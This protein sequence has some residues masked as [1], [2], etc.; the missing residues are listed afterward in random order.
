MFNRIRRHLPPRFPAM[1]FRD[2]V[3]VL[4]GGSRGLGLELARRFAAEG[5]KVALLARDP[6]ELNRA[7]TLLGYRDV[8]AIPCDVTV[9]EQVHTAVHEVVRTWGR[10]DV[11]VNN[12]GLI[13]VGPFEHM[14]DDDWTRS[15]DLHVLAPLHLVRACLP[16]MG[17][18]SRIV[19][20]SS[21]GGLVP[22]PHM[23]P[24][25]ASKHALVGLSGTLRAE[26]APR[27]IAVTTVC[28]WLT[29]TGSPPHV[30]VKGS[31]ADEYRWFAT[32]DN[33]PLLSQASDRAARRIVAATRR[34]DARL[35]PTVHGKL[36]VLAE[37]VAPGLVAWLTD[38][39][40]T[41]LPGPEPADGDTTRLGRD[42]PGPRWF[43]P[44]LAEAGRR[45]NE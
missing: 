19:N 35:V 25:T 30:E 42:L 12:A 7:V 40:V 14:A 10:V 17:R 8:L 22:V 28:P 32:S 20:V 36:A 39:F 3:V 2:R 34:G 43:A 27:G 33:A 18:G 37:A 29:R 26:L 11:L 38:V 1:D 45:N 9:L 6:A 21:I 24:Y 4:T 16:H 13:Q 31:H 23:A 44:T 41:F 15:L 5:A